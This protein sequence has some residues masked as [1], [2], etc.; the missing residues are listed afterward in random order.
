MKAAEEL[1]A[2]AGFYM[3]KDV[4]KRQDL[5]EAYSL[6]SDGMFSAGLYGD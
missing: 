3:T 6:I 1:S 4:Y 2:D 5:P